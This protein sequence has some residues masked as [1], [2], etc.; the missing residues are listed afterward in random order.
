VSI[1]DGLV[2]GLD[3]TGVINELLA[4]QRAP[5][6][7]LTTRQ[8]TAESQATTIASIRSLVEA[9][10]TAANAMDDASEWKPIKTSTSDSSIATV[11]GASGAAVGSV[12]F[13]VDRLAT[14]HQLVSNGTAMARTDEWA[15]GDI[16]L[17]ID[18]ASHVISVAPNV[19]SGVR[20]LDS[21]VEAVN[22]AN[23]GVRAQA[24]QVAPGEFRL[25]LEATSTG[26]ASEFQVVSGLV[27]SFDTSRQA[28]DARIVLAGGFEATSPTNTFDD[29]LTGI[30]VT[31]RKTS[32]DTVTVSSVQDPD[33]LATKVGALVTSVNAA[34]T[35]VKSVTRFDSITGTGSLLTGD[36]TVARV[37]RDLTRALIDAVPGS[38]VGAPSLAGITIS[39]DGT[40][41][42]DKAKFLSAYEDDPAGVQALFVGTDSVTDR[43]IDK[44]DS[45]SAFG[46]GYLRTAEELRRNQI[47]TIGEQ[48]SRIEARVERSAVALRRQFTLMETTMGTL[49]SQSKWLA[50]QIASLPTYNQGS[51]G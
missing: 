47:T 22:G 12:S 5:I 45:A 10:K 30:D 15:T 11:S 43:L 20:D 9:V 39:K 46:T 28:Y 34:L 36:S 48:I 8:K 24:V 4:L 1:I 41:S 33:A 7:R 27:P 3:T 35:A 29:L 32:P 13:T 50:G 16:T 17:D 49:Q 51:Q 25:Q 6:D 44:V 14:S 42:F 40:L 26:A 23:L 37:A 38:A 21:V 31:V 2:S 18:G 19:D